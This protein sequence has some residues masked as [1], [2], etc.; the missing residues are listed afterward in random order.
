VFRIEPGALETAHKCETVSRETRPAQPQTPGSVPKLPLSG[1]FF[2][3]KRS[4]MSSET[5]YPSDPEERGCGRRLNK[6]WMG[7][8]RPSPRRWL[9]SKVTSAVV[10]VADGESEIST[11]WHWLLAWHIALTIALISFRKNPSE[12]DTC[13]VR[14]D[15]RP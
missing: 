15:T 9:R 11:V 5:F 7:S 6:T 1:V 3:H 10:I 12:S 2:L 4:P 13:D 8:P 14:I